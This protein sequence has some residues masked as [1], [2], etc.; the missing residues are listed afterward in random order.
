MAITDNPNEL[1]SL[2]EASSWASTFLQ[3]T[4]TKSNIS[5]LIQYGRIRKIGENATAKIAKED[6]IKYYQYQRPSREMTWKKL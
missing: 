6:L 3:R 2:E 5:Y 4:V 1:L